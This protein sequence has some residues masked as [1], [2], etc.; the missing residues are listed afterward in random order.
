MRR[1]GVRGWRRRRNFGRDGGGILGERR[2]GRV[3]GCVT[4]YCGK[5]SGGG[6]NGCAKKEMVSK[7]G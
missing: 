6:R 2:G 5:V 7:T 1:G 3:D 4:Y